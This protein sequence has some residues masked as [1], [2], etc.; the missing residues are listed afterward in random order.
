MFCLLIC[1][2]DDPGFEFGKEQDIF[3]FSKTSRP[4][5][6]P[7]QARIQWVP[8]TLSPGIKRLGLEADQ[9]P[10]CSAEFKSE[11]SYTS[12]TPVCLHV[13]YKDNFAL[14]S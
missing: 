4:A 5:L 10:S 8:R 3:L 13:M 2:L 9:S 6:G 1:G 7:T 12:T 14:F 11:W